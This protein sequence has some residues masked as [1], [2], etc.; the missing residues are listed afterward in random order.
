[1][2]ADAGPTS[3]GIFETFFSAFID[4]YHAKRLGTVFAFSFPFS[5]L[6]SQFW[7][8]PQNLLFFFPVSLQRSQFPSKFRSMAFMDLNSGDD[9]LS[10]GLTSAYLNPFMPMKTDLC[11]KEHATFSKNV[12]FIQPWQQ[13]RIGPS[14]ELVCRSRVLTQLEDAPTVL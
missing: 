2:A 1:M 12:A 10:R 6:F 13:Q 3:G 7:S 4:L 11:Q 14:A 8:F 5:S 9:S